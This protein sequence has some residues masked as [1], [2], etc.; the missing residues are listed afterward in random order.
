MKHGTKITAEQRQEILDAYLAWGAKPAGKLAEQYGV[1]YN[2]GAKLASELGYAPRYKRYPTNRHPT[3]KNEKQIRPRWSD[4]ET[5]IARQLLRSGATNDMCLERLG[6]SFSACRERVERVNLEVVTG[7][8]A[9][10][11][12]APAVVLEER[13]RR[14]MAP[15]TVTGYIFGDPPLGYSALDK[16]NAAGA[17]A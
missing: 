3:F 4:E 8:S 9:V 11:P 5:E 16:R 17:P 7:P 6:R 12:K 14:Q 13:A 1:A 10:S 15:V 2:Y